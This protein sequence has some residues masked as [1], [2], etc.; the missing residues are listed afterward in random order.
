MQYSILEKIFCKKRMAL[1]KLP[2]RKR[3]QQF[4]NAEW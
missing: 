3:M 4:D 2:V 1:P